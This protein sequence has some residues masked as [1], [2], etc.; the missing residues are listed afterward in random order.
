VVGAVGESDLELMQ[1]TSYLTRRL[2]LARAY[3]SSFHPVSDTPFENLP[4]SSPIRQL[5]LYQASFLLRDYG[6]ELEDLPFEQDGRLP[7]GADPKLIW[8]RA[9]LAEAPLEINRANQHE[10][11]RV[12][13]IGVKGAKAIIEARRKGR[14]TAPEDLSRLG[15]L[16]ARALPFILLDGR[17]PAHQLPLPVL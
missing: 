7:L 3:F 15:I 2:R 14:L 16:P 9:N 12:P 17:R 4:R 5:R 8:A 13:G 11:L 6:F 1:T 10:L